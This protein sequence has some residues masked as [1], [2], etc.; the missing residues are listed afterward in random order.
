MRTE[1]APPPPFSRVE[2]ETLAGELIG[3][4]IAVP[5]GAGLGAPVEGT[6]VDESLSTFT[7]R[8]AARRRLVRI[9]KTGRAGTLIVGGAEIPLKGD[10]LRVRPEDRTKRL[11]AGGPRRFR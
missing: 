7:V 1:P 3:A 5:A 11:L 8:L 4:S 6:I 9:A 2:A 10:A